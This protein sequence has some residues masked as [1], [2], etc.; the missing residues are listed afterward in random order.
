M[1]APVG[2]FASKLPVVITL[3][4]GIKIDV[5]DYAKMWR[6][7]LAAPPGSTFTQSLCNW[8]PSSRDELLEQFRDGMHDRINRHIPGY[9]VGRKWDADWQNDTW[10]ASRE[11]NSRRIL[12]YLPPWLCDRF[13]QRLRRNRDD[14]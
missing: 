13:A 7:V 12:D 11:V 6:R 5:R 14:L 9:N 4:S 2:I 8:W 10:R 1:N 3:G